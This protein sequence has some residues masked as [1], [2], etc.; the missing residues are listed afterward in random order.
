MTE[1]VYVSTPTKNKCFKCSKR[2]CMRTL[3]KYCSEYFCFKCLQQEVHACKGIQMMINDKLTLLK[4]KL[5]SERCVK[6]KIECI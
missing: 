3:C 2:K 6:R 4:S 1:H 5:E